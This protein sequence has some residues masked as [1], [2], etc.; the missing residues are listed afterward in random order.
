VASLDCLA[1]RRLLAASQSWN[2]DIGTQGG[3]AKINPGSVGCPGF[4]SG[5]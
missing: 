4:L 5:E 1:L 3:G 2:A